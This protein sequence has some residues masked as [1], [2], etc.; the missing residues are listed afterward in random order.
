M[1]KFILAV[2]FFFLN[3][4]SSTGTS[5]Y[6]CSSVGNDTNG[7]TISQPWKSLAK[8]SSTTLSPGDTVFFRKGDRFEGH[9]V[10]NGSGSASQ[11]VVIAAYGAGNKP[12]LTGEVGLAGGGDFR[13]AIYINNND[14][15]VIEGLEINNERLVTRVDVDDKDSY[16]IL[17]YNSG[18]EIMSNFTFRN[19]TFRNVYAVLPILKP[20]DFNGLVVSALSFYTVKN[21]IAGQE[22]NIQN[23]LMEGCYFTDLQRFGV[24]IQHAGANPGI[25]NDSINRNMNFVF[26]N[27][28]FH[29]IGGTCIQPSMTYNCLIENNIFDHPGDNTDARMPNRGS[30]VWTWRCYNTVIQ[31]NEC[32]HIRGYLDSHGIHI[33]HENKNTFVQYN[34]MLDC[35]GGFVEILGGNVN[36]VYRFNVS[37]N[38]GWRYNPN[39]IN[40]NHTIFISKNASA[41][42]I[43]YCD[44]S[45]IY[46]NTVYIDSIFSTAIDMNAKNT[47]IFN[48]IFY[49]KNGGHIGGKQ[50]AIINNGYPLYMRNNLYYGAV[51][52]NFKNNDTNPKIGDPNFYDG[53]TVNKYGYQLN[54]GSTAINTGVA[55][56]GPRLPGAGTGI[57][58]KIPPY[59]TVDFYGNPIDMSFGTPNIG[60]CNAKSGEIFTGTGAIKKKVPMNCLIYP[61]P[62]NTTITIEIEDLR[63]A[64][65]DLQI[66]NFRGQELISLKGIRYKAE[67]DIS[68]L[69]SGIYFVKLIT[70]KTVEL[71]KIIKE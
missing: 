1:T 6:I 14:N 17:V 26:R 20:E 8:I 48:N 29:Y 71:R 16:G 57:F 58:I 10:V 42:Q 22:K 56:Q 30:S 28:E 37:V 67:V 63:F 62:A 38:D 39:W 31:Y 65:C 50:V 53:G 33:D 27:N 52:N 12:V 70:D 49:A 34:F 60:A 69:T 64:N 18:N 3:V 41:G 5:Y 51:A 23:V 47:F 4:F 46:N 19:L 68:N 15:I 45:Y 61:N 2:A 9:F 11:P 43:K 35:E 66:F 44:S 32:L 36:A 24:H 21:S 13:E 25:G 59:P 55:R 40:S 54:V 7:G